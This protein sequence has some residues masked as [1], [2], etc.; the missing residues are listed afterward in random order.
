MLS[1]AANIEV[2]LTWRILNKHSVPGDIA[3]GVYVCA[4]TALYIALRFYS[5]L[6]DHAL[7][8]SIA[9]TTTYTASALLTTAAYRLSPWHP[10]AKFPGPRLWHVSSLWLSW[11]SSKGR[12]HHMLDHLHKQ[13]GVFV[14][15]GKR[16]TRID[17]LWI[18]FS[19]VYSPECL[20]CQLSSWTVHLF[21]GGTHA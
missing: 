12:R 8:S 18:V 11:I 13:Y 19:S 15:I 10:L 16:A 3:V 9:L 21:L 7:W 20:I 1:G 2:Q 4:Y 6:T 5:S 14:R 17:V